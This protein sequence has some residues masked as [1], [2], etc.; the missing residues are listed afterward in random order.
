[1]KRKGTPMSV[2]DT[3]DEL[4]CNEETQQMFSEYVVFDDDEVFELWLACRWLHSSDM[5]W[6]MFIDF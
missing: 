2:E 5:Q 4:H 3:L 1:M 6:G